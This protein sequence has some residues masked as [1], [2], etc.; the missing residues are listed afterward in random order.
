LDPAEA[1]AKNVEALEQLIEQIRAMGSSPTP[2][3]R[4]GWR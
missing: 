4:P 2:S 3:S 1:H